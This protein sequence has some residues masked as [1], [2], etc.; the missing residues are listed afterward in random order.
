[1]SG[2]GRIGKDVDPQ[3]TKERRKREDQ[4]MLKLRTVYPYGLNDA[5]NEIV[6]ITGIVGRTFPSL[7]HSHSIS[8]IRSISKK[9]QID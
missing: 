1:M 9:Y 4:W 7:Q 2:H 6:D 5:L 8:C 3:I